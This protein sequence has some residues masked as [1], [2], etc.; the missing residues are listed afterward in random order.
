MTSKTLNPFNPHELA[1]LAVVIGPHHGKFRRP[2]TGD[3][4]SAIAESVATV[5]NLKWLIRHHEEVLL[6]WLMPIVQANFGPKLCV[7]AQLVD[8][9]WYA[10]K[11]EDVRVC[12]NWLQR[13]SMENI[14]VRLVSRMENSAKGLIIS[15]RVGNAV[16]FAELRRQTIAYMDNLRTLR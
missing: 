15:A 14:Q 13:P 8:D 4:T 1:S 2:L 3:D 6:I 9:E 16:E 5:K 10:T 12:L 11:F 7:V